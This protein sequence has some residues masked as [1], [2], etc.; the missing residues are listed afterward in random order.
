MLSVYNFSS[1]YDS[2]LKFDLC[3]LVNLTF[4]KFDPTFDPTRSKGSNEGEV[5]R[6]SY[7]IFIRSNITDVYNT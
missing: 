5:N 2:I 6:L 3:N 4:P 1:I 7:E